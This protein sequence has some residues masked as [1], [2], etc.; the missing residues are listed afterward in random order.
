MLYTYATD[1]YVFPED[2]DIGPLTYLLK[3]F[4]KYMQVFTK[5]YAV[6]MRVFTKVYAVYNCPYI[7]DPLVL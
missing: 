6:Y 4:K 1:Y 5:V 2:T 3:Y 7:N